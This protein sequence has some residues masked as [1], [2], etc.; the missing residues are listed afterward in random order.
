MKIKRFQIQVVF[1]WMNA[2]PNN[3]PGVPEA[4]EEESHHYKELGTVRTL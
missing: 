1:V 4:N 3:L 2:L